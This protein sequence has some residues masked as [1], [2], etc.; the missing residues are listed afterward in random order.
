QPEYITKTSHDKKNQKWEGFA[1]WKK[2]MGIT[3]TCS[4]LHSLIS[5]ARWGTVVETVAATEGNPET[6]SQH[7]NILL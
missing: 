4:V 3:E 5:R 1:V 7:T 2:T 6:H